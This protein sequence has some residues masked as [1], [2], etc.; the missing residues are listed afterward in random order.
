LLG[1]AGK[2][3]FTQ[4]ATGLRV[5]MPMQKLCDFAYVPKITGLKLA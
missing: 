2:L 1:H 5:K 4:E 3:A